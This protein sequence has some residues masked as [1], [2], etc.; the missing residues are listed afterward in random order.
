MNVLELEEE[1][2]IFKISSLVAIIFGLGNDT[3]KSTI[4]IPFNHKVG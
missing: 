4:D 2:S 3:T 1:P